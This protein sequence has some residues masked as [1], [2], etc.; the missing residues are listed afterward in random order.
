MPADLLMHRR[1]RI[2]N[3]QPLEDEVTV[4]PPQE[5]D[6]SAFETTE[7]GADT[8]D[9]AVGKRQRQTKRLSVNCRDRMLQELM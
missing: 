1:R 9:R 6:L 2:G 4:A 8:K 5:D 3:A 7:F